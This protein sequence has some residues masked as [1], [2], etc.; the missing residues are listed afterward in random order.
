[1]VRPLHPA[2]AAAGAAALL[3]LVVGLVALPLLPPDLAIHFATDGTPNT[4][5]PTPLGIVIT[6]AV[7]IALLLYLRG[8]QFAAALPIQTGATSA[9]AI[10]AGTAY[11]QVAILALNLGVN[12]PPLVAVAPCVVAILAGTYLGGTRPAATPQS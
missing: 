6:P 10:V 12:V 2:D 1:M 3:A 8:G 4:V 7:S 5:V 11:L 9:L